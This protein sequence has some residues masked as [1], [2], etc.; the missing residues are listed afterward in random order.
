MPLGASVQPAVSPLHFFWDARRTKSTATGP[1]VAAASSPPNTRDEVS[2]GSG[3]A[4]DFPPES[5]AGRMVSR[6][7]PHWN[8][9]YRNRWQQ[10]PHRRASHH[11]RRQRGAAVEVVEGGVERERPATSP[12]ARD[13]PAVHPG[14]TLPPLQQRPLSQRRSGK[15]SFLS[16]PSGRRDG[17]VFVAAVPNNTPRPKLPAWASSL[18]APSLGKVRLLESNWISTDTQGTVSPAA[19]QRLTNWLHAAVS[20]VDVDFHSQL[21]EN[22]QLH[23]RR[24]TARGI[25]AKKAFRSG[26]VIISL[27][28]ATASSTP[29][30]TPPGHT[31]ST[32]EAAATPTSP[33]AATAAPQS[34]LAQLTING[35]TLAASSPAVQAQKCLLSRDEVYRICSTRRSTFDP[36]P[37][38]LF[39]DQVYTALLLACERADGDASP[40]APFLDLLPDTMFDKDAIRELHVGVLDPRSL[41]EYEEHCGRFQHSLRELHRKWHDR[42]AAATAD[43]AEYAAKTMGGAAAAPPALDTL[44]FSGGGAALSP[45]TEAAS[46][47]QVSGAAPPNALPHAATAASGGSN[48]TCRPPPSLDAIEWAFRVVISRQK[49]LPHLRLR[50]HELQENDD[51]AVEGEKLDAFARGVMRAKYA[52]YRHLFRAMDVDPLQVN[53][54]SDSSLLPT[55]VPLIDML[56]HPPGGV[57]NT[58]YDVVVEVAKNAATDHDTTSATATATPSLVGVAA[59]GESS[60]RLVLR[61]TE[62]IEADEELTLVYSKC[63]SIAY[64]LYRYGFLPL[65]RRED[66]VAELLQQNKV[67]GE[68]RHAASF[69]DWPSL[70]PLRRWR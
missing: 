60:I 18:T 57:G 17:D 20:P 15:F 37:H 69:A 61:A 62:D 27:P 58:A 6:R 44:D 14:A 29:A 48:A 67:D 4:G 43:L 24:S 32:V 41:M 7:Q 26:E 70:W 52:V 11:Q 10:L 66:D 34:S 46:P 31:A 68:G 28:L 65:R 16:A 38:P 40:Y 33:A 13:R 8:S 5:G 45:P 9:A 59:T 50:R 12:A 64:T 22:I 54:A 3:A 30:S 19:M 35:E 1:E 25:Y 49:M 63:Y 53:R 36:I 51:T 47:S 42:Y 55:V 23:L 56:Q 39:I 21:S 2:D